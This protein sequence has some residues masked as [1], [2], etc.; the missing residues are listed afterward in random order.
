MR[1]CVIIPAY[2]AA[3]VV[4]GIV[5]EVQRQ[6]F[7]VVVVDDGSH[8]ETAAAAGRFGAVVLR[9]RVNHGKG[10]ALRKAF[11]YAL[12]QG[13]DAVV[14][15]D[16][17]G[18][19]DP[20]ELQRFLTA[21]AAHRAEMV[22][23]NRLHQPGPMPRVRR[24]T[25]RLMSAVLSRLAQ[26][27]VPDTQCGYRLIHRRLLA[28]CRLLS[29]RYDIESELVLEAALRRARIMSVPITAIYGG[30]RSQI[31]PWRDTWRFVRLV[32]RY[33]ARRLFSSNGHG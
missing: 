11:R 28:E 2:N 25:N 23:G 19:H 8:D 14:T 22:V 10:W 9:A 15:M 33:G 12:R 13:Y 6:G 21:A 17:D 18:Q 31:H 26:Q 20:A 4:G 24:W 16:A 30:E 7:D 32:S 1:C 29:R 5:A 27:R 3:A